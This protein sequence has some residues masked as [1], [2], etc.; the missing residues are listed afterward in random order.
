MR[1][2]AL[3]SFW[4]FKNSL[5]TI[6]T[7]PRKLVPVLFAVAMF[8]FFMLMSSFAGTPPP[9]K[10][11]DMKLSPDYFEGA[12]RLGMLFVVYGV[13]NYSLGDGLLALG[14]PDV[15]YV[16]PS[17]VSRRAVLVLKL[18]ALLFGTMFQ[19]IFLLF[20][21]RMATQTFVQASGA[22]LGKTHSPGWFA[23]AAVILCVAAYLNL[24]VFLS[25]QFPNRRSFKAWVLALFLLLALFLGWT[26]WRQ[27]ISAGVAILDSG[28]V[29]VLFWPAMLASDVLFATNFRQP[30]AAELGWLAL[31][32][33]LSLVPMF[34]SNANWYEQSV[35]ST[36]KMA[37]LRQAAKGGAAAVMA[38]RAEK[39]KYKGTRTY[40][41]QPFG[42][43]A[44]ALF[45]A[46][47]CS[48]GK[49]A[50]TNFG[51]PFAGG[52]LMGAGGAAAS[53]FERFTGPLLVLGLL[54]Y[55]SFGFMA[56]ART[57]CEAAVRRREL[58]AP[59]PIPAWQA[60][61]ADLGVPFLLMYLTCAGAALA[62]TVAGGAYGA[63]LLYGALI[64][65]PLRTASRMT[66]QYVMVLGYPDFADKV[67]QF[68]AQF[69][70]WLLAAP[71]L[72]AE[73]ILCLPGIFLK[74]IWVGA[75]TLTVYEAGLVVA[76]LALAGKASSRSVATGEPVRIWSLLKRA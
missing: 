45:W 41:V 40:T 31:V 44:G 34:L 2:I 25:V 35:V 53:Y 16:F 1:A 18:P 7:D 51:L 55:G 8:G 47:L 50:L 36:E 26:V 24:G 74:S 71:F 61:A 43:G 5:R 66:L 23:P 4:K 75:L 33:V 67:Q 65:Y 37:T 27:G 64:L 56:S 49:R 48:A 68:V 6:F 73:V 19:A 69:A 76:F 39:H 63:Y 12:V 46:H 57:A 58:I 70:Y 30:V 22:Y 42:Q 13:L 29:R 72:L 14:R 21:F 9:S 3:L 60:V 20:S 17:P 11:A 28:A 15:D 59:L 52:I 38:A 62:Y 10:A 54:L 32:F